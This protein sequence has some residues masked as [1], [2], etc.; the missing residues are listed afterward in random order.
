MIKV[1]AAILQK[2]DKILIARKK[3]GKLAPADIP[4]IEK[5]KEI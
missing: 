3:E 4:F 2:D 5:L 1:V